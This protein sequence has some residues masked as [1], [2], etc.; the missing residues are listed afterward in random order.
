MVSSGDFGMV[1]RVGILMQATR[2]WMGGVVYIQNLIKAIAALPPDITSQLELHLL[3]SPDSD[4]EFYQG[5]IPLVSGVHTVDFL[6][7]EIAH[8]LRWKATQVFPWLKGKL[9]TA[10]HIASQVSFDFFYP[11]MGKYEVTWGFENHMAAWIP[12]FQHK[13]L[14]NLFSAHELDIRE[15]NFQF[16]ADRAPMI[17]FSSQTALADFQRFYPTSTA[18]LRVLKFRTIPEPDW[19]TTDPIAVQRHYQLPDRFFLVSNQFW[20]HKN[21]RLIIEALHLLKQENIEPIVVCTGSLHDYRCPGYGDELLQQIQAY[22]LESQF[23][24]L[25][26]VPRL[27]QIQLMRRALAVIQPSLF[28]GWSTVVEDARV[29]G[30]TILLSDLPVHQEQ[31][32]PHAHY[33]H[34]HSAVDL[35]QT[36]KTLLPDLTAGPHLMAEA[37]ARHLNQ[38]QC[39]IYAQDFLQLVQQNLAQC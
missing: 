11:I 5:L 23:H 39:Q 21:H 28:E 29:L 25:G 22:Q 27:D 34:R 13:H 16:L 36:L 18:Q 19:Y 10:N 2:H 14:P 9:I 32:P 3:I 35:A 30:Q 8:K 6:N 26:L 38:E 24:F 15:R 12:D 1:I 17:V 7:Q 33:F 31:A 20:T 37:K 4:P